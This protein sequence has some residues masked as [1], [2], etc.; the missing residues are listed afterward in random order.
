MSMSAASPSCREIVVQLNA[1]LAETTAA[2]VAARGEAARAT[3]QLTTAQQRHQEELQMM[4]HTHKR[5]HAA[6][7]ALQTSKPGTLV[8]AGGDGLVASHQAAPPANEAQSV[9][10]QQATQHVDRPG[11]GRAA[12]TAGASCV[13]ISGAVRAR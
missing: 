4:D 11:D 13:S 12:H 2:E 5:L 9:D 8:Q 1:K 6:I 7:A 10:Q 3:T